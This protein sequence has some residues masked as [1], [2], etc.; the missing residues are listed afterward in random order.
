MPQAHAIHTDYDERVKQSKEAAAPAPA[1]IQPEEEAVEKAP[2]PEPPLPPP[3]AFLHLKAHP[4]LAET[5]HD[6]IK[7][8]AR[9]TAEHGRRAFTTPLAQ[10]E[11]RNFQFEFLKPGHSLHAYF[12]ALVDAYAGI[13]VDGREKHGPVLEQ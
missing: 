13:L 4:P 9:F 3:Y 6:I 7:L 2:N 8:A 11:A 12:G 1:Q 5:D 10:R